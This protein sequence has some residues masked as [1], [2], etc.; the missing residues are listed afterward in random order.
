MRADGANAAMRSAP[1][2][3]PTPTTLAP[4]LCTAVFTGLA[5]TEVDDC[6]TPTVDPSAL[7]SMSQ[8]TQNMSPCLLFTN[9]VCTHRGQHSAMSVQPRS[10]RSPMPID[11]RL[12]EREHTVERASET[13]IDR[14]GNGRTHKQRRQVR[15]W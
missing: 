10:R 11:T 12:R 3:A 8:H 4:G 1:L 15:G 9:G 6:C 5:A 7:T 2:P 13:T 14:A